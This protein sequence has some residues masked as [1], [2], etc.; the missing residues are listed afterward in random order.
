VN[1]RIAIRRA[2]GIRPAGDACLILFIELAR[3]RSIA[4]SARVCGFVA[5]GTLA[6]AC[7]DATSP[8]ATSPEM[9][10]YNA[11][12]PAVVAPLEPVVRGFVSGTI[13][14][15]TFRDMR[16]WG[17]TVVRLQLHP[18]TAPWPTLLDSMESNVRAAGA[19]GLKVVIDMHNAP[20]ANP[21]SSSLWTDATLE[22]NLISA[23]TDIALRLKSYGQIIWGY[24]LLNEPLDRAQLPSAPRQWRPMAVQVVTAIRAID[25]TVWIIYE[26]GPGSLTYGFTGLKPLPDRRVIYSLHLYDPDTF[27]MQSFNEAEAGELQAPFVRW[28]GALSP[29]KGVVQPAVEFQERWHVPIYVGEF[30]VVR[31]APEPDGAQWLNDVISLCESHGWS[32]TYFAFREHNAWSVEDDD[33]YWMRPELDPLP[34]AAPSIRALTVRAALN[35]NGAPPGLSVQQDVSNAAL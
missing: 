14:A 33:Q 32:W 23:W 24:D 25:S 16:A 21:S 4:A 27:T 34:A 5:I 15:T 17:A 10:I 28:R 26:P 7:A 11:P 31:W 13:D 2:H 29:L 12:R 8:S 1:A 18:G 35:N 3:T 30:S 9:M 6:M 19:A 22:P 20:V